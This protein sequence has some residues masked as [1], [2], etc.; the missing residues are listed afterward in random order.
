MRVCLGG[1]IA[2]TLAVAP[3][4]AA[5][6]A[7][8]PGG[9]GRRQARWRASRRCSLA[10]ERV[11]VLQVPPLFHLRLDAV[12]LSGDVFGRDAGPA[13]DPAIADGER[14]VVAARLRAGELPQLQARL[15]IADP[16]VKLRQPDTRR[17]PRPPRAAE[18]L[19]VQLLLMLRRLVGL[20]SLGGD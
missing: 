11:V 1:L 13:I 10:R 8:C 17:K 14:E 5:M 19:A 9:G 2:A 4:A 18:K 3:I 7:P 15:A 12:D 20:V 6:P 16:D